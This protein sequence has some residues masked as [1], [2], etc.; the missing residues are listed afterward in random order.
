MEANNLEIKVKLG[1]PRIHEGETVQERNKV[2][3]KK[4]SETGYFRD[5]YKSKIVLKTCPHCCLTLNIVSLPKHQMSKMCK[6]SKQL[7]GFLNASIMYY[8]KEFMM[9]ILT[10]VKYLLL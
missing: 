9:K 7:N 3:M 5:Y 8:N 10:P 1:R 4:K 2:R 6:S